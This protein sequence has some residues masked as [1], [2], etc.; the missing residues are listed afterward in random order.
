M[1]KI[2]VPLTLHNAPLINSLVYQLERNFQDS[3]FH[4]D[5]QGKTIIA[6]STKYLNVSG[7]ENFIHD[8]EEGFHKFGN[9]IKNNEIWF[10]PAR[11]HTQTMYI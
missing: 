11:L 9:K 1:N 5:I 7:I 4:F 8:F 3:Y 10:L 6:E 2:K